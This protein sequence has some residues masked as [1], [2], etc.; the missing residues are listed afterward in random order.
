MSVGNPALLAPYFQIIEKNWNPNGTVTRVA[1]ANPQR[2]SLVFN[3]T[4]GSVNV[5]TLPTADTTKG[6]LMGSSNNSLILTYRDVGALV[7]LDWWAFVQF[8]GNGTL[9]TI[10]TIY[11]P[12]AA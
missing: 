6:I 7:Q 10:E 4:V 3:C 11:R 2:I 8:N 9:T 12:P 5:S 1:V